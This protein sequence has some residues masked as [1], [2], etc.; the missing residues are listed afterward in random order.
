MKLC[1]STCFP[2]E[3]CS[4]TWHYQICSPFIQGV[5]A[6]IP[7][8]P[9]SPLQNSLPPEGH[10]IPAGELGTHSR[11]SRTIPFQRFPNSTRKKHSVFWKIRPQLPPTTSATRPV[12]SSSAPRRQEINPAAKP[13]LFSDQFGHWISSPRGAIKCQ[14]V[15]EEHGKWSNGKWSIPLVALSDQLISNL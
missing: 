15:R 9:T 10:E 4:L 7:H 13:K 2:K 8:S 12:G 14:L 11:E 3:R 5:T 1:I 6:L